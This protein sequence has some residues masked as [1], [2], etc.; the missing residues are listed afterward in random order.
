M[1]IKAV[2]WSLLPLGESWKCR[3]IPEILLHAGQFGLL[4]GFSWSRQSCFLL[5]LG[6]DKGFLGHDRASWL[7]VATWL[8]LCCDMVFSFKLWEMSQNGV[9]LLRQV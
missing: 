2:V 5:V 1:C 7:Y 9:S 4:Q 8:S 3:K 6:C